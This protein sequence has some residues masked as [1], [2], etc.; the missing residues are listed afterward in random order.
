MAS[1]RELRRLMSEDGAGVR[2]ARGLVAMRSVDWTDWEQDFLESIAT[3]DPSRGL[4]Y[5]QAEILAELRDA[6][7]AC[8][9]IAG[10]PVRRLIDQLWQARLDLSEDDEEWLGGLRAAA[11]TSV[12]KRTAARLAASARRIGLI[13][14]HV[15]LR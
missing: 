8:V 6:A 15:G 10:I 12:K 4:S 13:E 7:S 1:E 2:L 3:R 5:R 14:S 9:L 11:V